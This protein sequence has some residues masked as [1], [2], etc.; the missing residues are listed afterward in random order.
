MNLP[1][2]MTDLR[3]PGCLDVAEDGKRFETPEWPYRLGEAFDAIRPVGEHV[4]PLKGAHAEPW[5]DGQIR[6]LAVVLPDGDEPRGICG[7]QANFLDRDQ[8]LLIHVRPV[9]GGGGSGKA[10]DEEGT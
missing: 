6:D 1:D 8:E 4:E 3:T 2:G 10:G 9:S 5:G 7:S